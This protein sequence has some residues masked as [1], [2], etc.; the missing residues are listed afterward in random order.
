M[1]SRKGDSSGDAAHPHD[2][3]HGRVVQYSGFAKTTRLPWRID[4]P[5]TC[6][7]DDDGFATLGRPAGVAGNGSNRLS[8][9]V[10]QMDDNALGGILGGIKKENTGRLPGDVNLDWIAGDSRDFGD[11]LQG[12]PRGRGQLPGDLKVDLVRRNKQKRRRY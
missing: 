5:E 11:G 9:G 7:I 6:R 12:S 8:G 1:E 3:Q 4:G 10:I 2:G